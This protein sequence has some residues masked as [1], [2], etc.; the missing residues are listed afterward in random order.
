MRLADQFKGFSGIRNMCAAAAVAA[1]VSLSAGMA[2]AAN[3]IVDFSQFSEGDVLNGAFDFGGGLTGTITT[4]NLGTKATGDAVIFN[5]V[6]PSASVNNDPDLRGPFTNVNDPQ[7]IRDFGKVLI[8]QEKNASNPDDASNGG[9]ITFTFDRLVSL[10]AI[11][12]LDGNDNTPTGGSIFLDGSS[13]ALATNLGG[14]D[15]EFEEFIFAPGTI[16]SSFTVDFSGSGAIGRFGA[17]VVPVP[18][19]L[20]LLLTGF[21][22]FAWVA[23]R[24]RSSHA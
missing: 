4:G 10:T 24:R 7:D 15:R 6:A 1:A 23:R 11:F 18:A 16:V 5:T 21:G 22:V 14:G 3:V 20:P 12:L 2:Q 8:L 19:S 17:A 9:A 13:T